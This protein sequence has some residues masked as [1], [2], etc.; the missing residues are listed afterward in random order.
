MDLS[1]MNKVNFLFFSFLSNITNNVL[2]YLY[3]DLH[4]MFCQIYDKVFH[5]FNALI[6]VL[7]F[8]ALVS[9]V[10][11]CYIEIQLIFVD[12]SHI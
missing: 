3:T 9:D 6:N 4:Y 5:V 8:K 11:C 7:I 12:L 1:L 2:L 10:H